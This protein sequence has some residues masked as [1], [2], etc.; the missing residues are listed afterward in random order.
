MCFT[1]TPLIIEPLS[2]TGLVPIFV[3]SWVLSTVEMGSAERPD[4]HAAML[5]IERWL[6]TH[7]S[8]PASYFT[9]N[10]LR[11]K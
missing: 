6:T 10:D 1:T 11:G 5:D 2:F 7:P 8:W 3:P 9:S 4:L